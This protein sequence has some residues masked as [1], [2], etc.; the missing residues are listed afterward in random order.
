[1]AENRAAFSL[2]RR[3][4]LG[5]SKCRWLRTTFNVPS[6]SILFFNRRSALS[7]GSPFLSLIS[8]K[9]LSLPLQGPRD[10]SDL[11]GPRSRSVRPQRVFCRLELSTR[12]SEPGSGGTTTR[13]PG[14][15]QT[16]CGGVHGR[17]V[18]GGPPAGAK[19]PEACAFD[20]CASPWCSDG[21]TVPD[22]APLCSLISPFAVSR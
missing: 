8:V 10:A 6:R 19:P 16:G 4:S 12:K 11:H 3:R 20:C 17:Q 5:F 13:Q 9:S 2:R 21:K 1:M 15:Q 22:G 7:T 14:R 18:A